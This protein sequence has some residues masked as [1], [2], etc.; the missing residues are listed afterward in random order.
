MHI[1]VSFL[2][3]IVGKKTPARSSYFPNFFCGNHGPVE[4]D[5]VF[6]KRDRVELM[7]TIVKY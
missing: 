2:N 3:S 4:G 6:P 7:R 1:V 5:K